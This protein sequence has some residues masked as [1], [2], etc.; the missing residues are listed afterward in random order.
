LIELLVSMS[1]LAILMAIAIPAYRIVHV[2]HQLAVQANTFLTALYFARGEAIK[3]NSRVALCKSSTGEACADAG[4]WQQGWIVFVDGNNDGSRDE[5]ERL[6]LRG[7]ALPVGFAM[8]GNGPLANYVSYTPLGLTSLTSG[9]FQAGTI[10][11]CPPVGSQGA[12]R[13]VVISITGRPRI[14]KDTAAA[15]T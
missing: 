1:V 11:L 13:R 9:A 4:N 14:D 3:R 15:C 7:P 12:A 5:T 8:K 6:L 10:T 2:N